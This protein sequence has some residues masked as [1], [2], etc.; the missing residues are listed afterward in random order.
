[1]IIKILKHYF[2]KYNKDMGLKNKTVSIPF[3]INT[4]ND[5]DLII[6]ML[7]HEDE[8]IFSEY[9]QNIYKEKDNNAFSSLMP[10]YAI[11]RKV[12]SDFGF[13]T[14][15]DSVEN[16]RKIFS[17]YYKSANDYDAEVLSSV[18]YM[19]ENRCV[20]YSAPII[21]VGDTI[22]D[23]ELYNLDGETKN[24]IKNIL[25]EFDHAFICGFSSS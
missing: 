6:Q 20:Y 2:V 13:D 22:P 9:G 3:S 11:N 25:G 21:N 7:K 5:R 18:V 23:C 15:D 16:Y 8:I 12:L 14:S 4:I 17:H 19:R 1:M 10:E 24:N